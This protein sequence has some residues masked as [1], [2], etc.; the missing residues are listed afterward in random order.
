[1]GKSTD[2]GRAWARRAVIVIA[3]ACAAV[4]VS[5][6]LLATADPKPD[7]AAQ[8]SAAAL[9]HPTFKKNEAAERER[10]EKRDTAEEKARR[11]ESRTKYAGLDR[12]GAHRTAKEHFPQQMHGRP[13]RSDEPA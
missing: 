2:R 1:M 7:P 9:K 3:A 8:E 6:P 13:Y 5:V 10:L 11:A 12:A 4:A